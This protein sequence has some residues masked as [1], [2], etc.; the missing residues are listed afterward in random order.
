MVLAFIGASFY[1]VIFIGDVVGEDGAFLRWQTYAAAAV[2][3]AA[4][5]AIGEAISWIIDRL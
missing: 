1:G 5:V 3:T 2:V 4:I